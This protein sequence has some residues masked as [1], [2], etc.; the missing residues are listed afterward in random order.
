MSTQLDSNPT[1]TPQST[2]IHPP[3]LHVRP[4]RVFTGDSI[5]GLRRRSTQTHWAVFDG[6]NYLTTWD[7]RKRAERHASG[8]PVVEKREFGGGFR[9]WRGA[10]AVESASESAALTERRRVVRCGCRVVLKAEDF[11]RGARDY[12][13]GLVCYD[14][15]AELCEDARQERLADES[16]VEIIAEETYAGLPAECGGEE[17]GDVVHF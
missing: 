11:K 12:S 5:R 8:T 17:C 3:G 13:N 1:L 2:T 10:W 15:F 14:C 4:R 7:T 16:Y 9:V 6:E